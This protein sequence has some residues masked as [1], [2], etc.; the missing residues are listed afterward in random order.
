MIFKVFDDKKYFQF[1]LLGM[2]D[3]V[4]NNSVLA[5]FE[6]NVV[7]RGTK[8]LIILK[9]QCVQQGE[10][11][12]IDRSLDIILDTVLYSSSVLLNLFESIPEIKASSGR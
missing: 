6:I 1:I 8:N 10:N 12:N 11:P 4:K 7:I 3:H 2:S 5:F 9:I